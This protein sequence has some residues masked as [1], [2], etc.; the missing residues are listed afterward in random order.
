ML[1]LGSPLRVNAVSYN[2]KGVIPTHPCQVL[3]NQRIGIECL[4][5][6]FFDNTNQISNYG[7]IIG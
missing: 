5:K 4:E 1:S 6:S 2:A 3:K 7:W